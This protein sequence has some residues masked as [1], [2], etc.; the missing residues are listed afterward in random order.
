V[1]LQ[2]TRWCARTTRTFNR[3][4][5]LW[6]LL[7]CYL[8]VFYFSADLSKAGTADSWNNPV[9]KQ[10]GVQF[11]VKFGLAWQRWK[12]A[13]LSAIDQRGWLGWHLL[14]VKGNTN[15]KIPTFLKLNQSNWNS[16]NQWRQQYIIV[17]TGRIIQK[18]VNNSSL[19]VDINNILLD[20]YRP[21]SNA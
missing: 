15:T 13:R 12:L 3:I 1:C 10:I 19:V 16:I 17:F 6:C 8:R 21:Y 7:S 14:V 4:W 18:Y 5:Q 11:D 2:R 9:R 20:S